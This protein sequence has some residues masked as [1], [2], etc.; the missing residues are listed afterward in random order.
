MSLGAETGSLLD[1]RTGHASHVLSV[2]SGG[3]P[4]EGFEDVSTSWQRSARYHHVDPTSTQAPR[5]LTPREITERR[6]PIDALISSARPE[7]DALYQR[8]RDAGYVLLFCDLGGVAVDYRGDDRAADAFRYWGAWLGGVWAED[9]EGTNGIG[10]CVVEERPIT[11]HRAQHFR[12]RNTDLSCSGAPIFDERGTLAA[13]LDVSAIDPQLSEHAHALT[14]VLT[15]EWARAIEERLFREHFR[16]NWIVALA[17]LEDARRGMLLALDGD[18]HI[19]G[20]DRT[21]RRSLLLDDAK[22]AAGISLWSFFERDGA[23]FRVTGDCVDRIARL[24]CAGSI[25]TC[26]ALLTPPE[27]RVLSAD[28]GRAAIY[29]RPRL[30]VVSSLPAGEL[31]VPQR[32]GLPGG[33]MRRVRDY[34]E[35]HLGETIDL[36]TLAEQ[37]G[38]SVFHF[39][40]QFKQTTGLTPHLYLLTRRIGQARELL[41]TTELS[42][43]E[44]AVMTGFADQSHFARSFRRLAGTSPREFRWSQ[45]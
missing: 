16:R 35:L 1:A 18:Q 15:E 37:A 44:I 5:I 36:P 11:V 24:V 32:G 45:R 25:D 2:A 33:A 21:A 6:A 19:V 30:D 17:P 38:S 42:I 20:A 34:I 31:P 7:I 3:M 40:R 23:L 43:A 10:T 4:G 41:A 12:S 22:I 26:A 39:A 13:V 8:V 29:T 28:L 9:A 27:S 14:G